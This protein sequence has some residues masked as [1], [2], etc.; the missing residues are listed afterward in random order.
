ME[1]SFPNRVRMNRTGSRGNSEIGRNVAS[2]SWRRRDIYFT[3]KRF[4]FLLVFLFLSGC[5]SS[6][7]YVEPTIEFSKLP[8]AGLG[9]PEKFETVVGRVTDAR[10]GRRVVL[11]AKSGKWWVQP[12][13]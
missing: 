13:A 11:F 4:Q 9:G 8:R 5:A 10:P 7:T 12:L 1:N 3:W 6:S 2:R